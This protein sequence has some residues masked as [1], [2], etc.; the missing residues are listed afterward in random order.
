MDIIKELNNLIK[1]KLS[2]DKT[3]HDYEHTQRV[4]KNALKIAEENPRADLEILKISC[5]L[6]D[7]AFQNKMTLQ[8]IKK[9]NISGAKQA[10]DILRKMNFPENKIQKISKAI[11]FHIR[12]ISN[13][14]IDPKEDFYEAQV[15]LDADAL[16]A[17]GSIG[18]I[19]MINFCQSQG[20][21]IFKSKEDKLNDSIYGGIKFLL[22]YPEKIMTQKGKQ[23]SE[24]RIQILKDFL[25]QLEKEFL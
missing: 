11:L 24:Q 9:H 21:P 4:L 17:L 7:I 2:C 6:H 19:R 3:S 8:E 14:T 22:S 25:K 12:S 16:D 20:F 15:L 1:E 18:L 10:E 23:I 13:V 5:L